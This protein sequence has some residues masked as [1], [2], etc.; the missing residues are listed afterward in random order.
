[1]ASGGGKPLF[2]TGVAALLGG[3]AV[4]R[5]GSR[6][7]CRP[8]TARLAVLLSATV[9]AGLMRWRGSDEGTSGD[10]F[11]LR[12]QAAATAAWEEQLD[13]DYED[14]EEEAEEEEEEYVCLA[15]PGSTPRGGSTPAPG[16]SL[17]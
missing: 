12:R 13:S 10:V 16:C 17:P 4:S 9:S 2:A 11:T 5:G 15:E 8:E 3:L 7:L 1:M 14:A 6:S